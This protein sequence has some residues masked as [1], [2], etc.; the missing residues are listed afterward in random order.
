MGVK[1]NRISFS[2]EIVPD[3]TKRQIKNML[4]CKH[5]LKVKE[6]FEIIE[7]IVIGVLHFEHLLSNKNTFLEY[8]SSDTL[9]VKKLEKSNNLL[10]V[11]RIK[12]FRVKMKTYKCRHLFFLQK[13]D[14]GEVLYTYESPPGYGLIALRLIGWVWFCYSV[15]FTLK[16]YKSKS[17]F[18]YPFFIFYTIW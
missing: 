8:P 2:T 11:F 15:F 5:F 4:R 10:K 17:L 16:N 1:K 6:K 18:Y 12:I 3:I 7:I 13:F 9:K 14:P